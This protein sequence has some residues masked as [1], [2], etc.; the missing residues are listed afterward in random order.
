MVNY[1]IRKKPSI[2][3]DITP[4]MSDII[5][6][7]LQ[8]TLKY[9]LDNS[10]LSNAKI[11]DL[12]EFTFWSNND[13]FWNKREIVEILSLYC[14]SITFDSCYD[15]SLSK[16]INEFNSNSELTK[17]LIKIR[18]NEI[19]YKYFSLMT[20]VVDKFLLVKKIYVK[21]VYHKFFNII[22]MLPDDIVNLIT[23]IL[24]YTDT[25]FPV[26]FNE[27]LSMRHIRKLLFIDQ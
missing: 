27:F 21:T 19:Y 1:I 26:Y 7:N 15:P 10:S 11:N 8:E 20:L 4:Y 2:N 9:V 13:I 16:F 6:Y 23:N 3:M 18:K 5:N 14:N 12:I 25:L 17:K 22:N 24:S